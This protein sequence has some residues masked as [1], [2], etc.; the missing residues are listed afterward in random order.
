MGYWSWTCNDYD[1]E[2]TEEEKI[3]YKGLDEDREIVAYHDPCH[4]GRK[5]GLFDK[6]REI[7][8]AVGY[9]LIEMDLTKKDS[10]CCGGGGGVKSNETN[11][12]NQIA[13]ARIDQAKKTEQKYLS[14]VV[15]CVTSI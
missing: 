13:Q 15:L 3:K 11:L 7:I 2:C 12:A 5:M 8:K 9:E 10:Y 1:F 6:P 14:P 4:L